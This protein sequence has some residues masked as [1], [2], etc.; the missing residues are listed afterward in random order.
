[1]PRRRQASTAGL[2]FHVINR[3][4]KRVPLF[5]DALDYDAFIKVLLEAV[6]RHDVALFAYCIMP[7][8]WHFLLSP[9]S[10]GALSRFMH[11]LTTTHARRW[12]TARELDGY[13]AVYQGRYKAI[14]VC[15]DRYLWVCRYVERNALRAALVTRAEQWPWSSLCQRIKAENISWLSPWPVT[16][17]DDWMTHV[18]LPQTDAEVQAFRRAMKMGEPFGEE[19]WRG[20]I[21]ARL[22]IRPRRDRGRPAKAKTTVLEK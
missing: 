9:R 18:N 17:P 19:V 6:A 8:H 5:E 20:A 11:W 12:Q 14:P 13:G 3:A 7:N 4:A 22:G 15:S 1:M 16:P 21:A 10:D 2:I